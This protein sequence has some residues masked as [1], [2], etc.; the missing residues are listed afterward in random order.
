MQRS[1]ILAVLLIALVGCQQPNP[2][3]DLLRENF[4]LNEWILQQEIHIDEQQRKISNLEAQVAAI[5]T[6]EEGASDIEPPSI[7]FG[8]D[9]GAA[10]AFP[11]PGDPGNPLDDEVPPPPFTPQGDGANPGTAAEGALN[12]LDLILPG[13]NGRPGMPVDSIGQVESIKID[14]RRTRALNL[15]GVPG[16]DGLVV[17][18]EPR[19][20]EEEPL[21][22]LA[23]LTIVAVDPSLPDHLARV[24]RWDYEA[25]EVRDLLVQTRQ[26]PKVVCQLLWP[27]V[28]PS[29]SRLQLYVRMKSDDDREFQADTPLLADFAGVEASGDR[30]A[31]AETSREDVSDSSVT[32]D[33]VREVPVPEYNPRRRVT[34]PDDEA[35]PAQDRQ[36]PVRTSQRAA[37]PWSPT[38]N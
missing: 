23:D 36:T 6:F 27:N 7:D 18:F 24:A 19:D 35:P 10:P 1:C 28:P 33:V 31:R 2:C 21:A 15:D 20:A 37:P 38:R 30:F 26:G 22:V 12:E 17:V 25:A 5:D 16:D 4:E 32:A 14:P 29:S 11:R 13:L 9:G 34:L 8:G 3:R